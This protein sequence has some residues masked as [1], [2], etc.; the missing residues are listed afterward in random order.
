MERVFIP[1]GGGAGTFRALHF[2]KRNFH[3]GAGP[4]TGGLSFAAA[5][6]FRGQHCGAGPKACGSACGKCGVGAGVCFGNGV[7]LCMVCPVHDGRGG[8]SVFLLLGAGFVV[9]KVVD[10]EATIIIARKGN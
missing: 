2:Y 1:N 5:F 8:I 3:G 6:C 4:I 7:S 10:G 9:E